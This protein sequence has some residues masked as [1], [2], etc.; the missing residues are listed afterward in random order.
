MSQLPRENLI[1]RRR[2]HGPLLFRTLPK[3]TKTPQKTRTRKLSDRRLRPPL[4]A[5]A[6][7]EPQ[8]LGREE[9]RTGKPSGTDP[10]RARQGTVPKG[11]VW[12]RGPA[13]RAALGCSGPELCH[14][15]K[16]G[17]M[18]DGTPRADRPK[19]PPSQG[20][21]TRPP[22]KPSCQVKPEPELQPTCRNSGSTFRCSTWLGAWVSG[23]VPFFPLQNAAVP[24][25]L[26]G[27]NR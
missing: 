15:R 22:P 8:V 7:Q 9:G 20:P 17:R 26:T 18:A 10:D 19:K 25:S 4:S 3:P 13:G 12:G 11:H 21:E 16:G 5:W 2:N 1:P 23:S 24:G 27:P 14:G 6:G